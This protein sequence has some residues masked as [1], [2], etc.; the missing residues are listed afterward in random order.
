[1]ADCCPHGQCSRWL[2]HAVLVTQ[3]PPILTHLLRQCTL[4][5]ASCS[6][7]CL[8]MHTCST[9]HGHATHG[10]QEAGKRVQQTRVC[11]QPSHAAAWQ[12]R[13]GGSVHIATLARLPKVPASHYYYYVAY[14][15]TLHHT[16]A[17]ASNMRAASPAA[18]A[19]H[20]AAAGRLLALRSLHLHLH[21]HVLV[22]ARAP[23]PAPPARGIGCSLD[24][25][26]LV[27]SV[28]LL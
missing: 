8:R 25:L 13:G 1:M 4:P 15:T 3:G 10:K 19:P 20:A 11:S 2:N 21:L 9:I 16:W 26:Y 22:A 23:A 24:R 5:A 7:T 12:V 28:S 27:G 18:A 6:T 14:P 17:P